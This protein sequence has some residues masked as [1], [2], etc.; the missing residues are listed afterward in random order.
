MDKQFDSSI[1]IGG[2]D[3]AREVLA[4]F[5]ERSAAFRFEPLPDDNYCFHYNTEHASAIEPFASWFPVLP[6]IE[7]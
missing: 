5:L 4:A 2:E 3:G 1:V 6:P 7:G